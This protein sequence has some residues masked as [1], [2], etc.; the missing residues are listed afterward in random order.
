[1]RLRRLFSGLLLCA[2]L[3][4]CPGPGALAEE[5]VAAPTFSGGQAWYLSEGKLCTLPE[6]AL[7][8]ALADLVAP[9]VLAE[10]VRAPLLACDGAVWCL[11][12]TALCRFSEGETDLRWTFPRGKE[13]TALLS[14]GAALLCVCPDGLYALSA[15]EPGTGP[16]RLTDESGWK[17]VAAQ[18]GSLFSDGTT[19]YC[20]TRSQIFRLTDQGTEPVFRVIP[21]VNEGA[22]AVMNTMG[23]FAARDG[24]LYYVLTMAQDYELWRVRT[25]G[26]EDQRLG[27]VCP[28]DREILGLSLSDATNTAYVFFRD[29]EGGLALSS[30]ALSE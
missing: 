20:G 18:G 6:A 5:G 21:L 23:P 15:E 3:L 2:V 14:L 28:P 22:F 26:R 9:T 19:L 24:W 27:S 25:D 13:P 7:S 4:C 17:A 10:S 30:F 8:D 1:M 16:Q 29:A 11:R 12:D